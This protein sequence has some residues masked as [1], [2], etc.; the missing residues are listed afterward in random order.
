MVTKKEITTTEQ[1]HQ[2]LS[3]IVPISL[4]TRVTGVPSTKQSINLL[5]QLFI[6]LHDNVSNNV[7]W[8]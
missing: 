7:K 2:T 4:S 5:Y 1:I 3:L 8:M 6:H